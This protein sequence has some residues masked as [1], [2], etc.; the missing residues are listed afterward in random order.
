MKMRPARERGSSISKEAG[1]GAVEGEEA[2]KEQERRAN[3]EGDRQRATKARRGS[4]NSSQLSSSS[5]SGENSSSRMALK[6]AHPQKMLLA[7]SRQTYTLSMTPWEWLAWTSMWANATLKL[8]GMLTLLQ[9]EEEAIRASNYGPRGQRSGAGDQPG[10]SDGTS[11]TNNAAANRPKG[12]IRPRLILDE[13]AIK[14]AVLKIAAAYQLRNL[15]SDSLPLIGLAVQMRIRSLLERML[16]AQ[17]HRVSGH[18]MRPPPMYPARFEG[19]LPAPM[20]DTVMYDDVD[21]IVSTFDRLE[22]EEERQARKDRLA[23]DQ[24]EHEER[25]RIERMRRE[26]EENGEEF[27]MPP[28][29]SAAAAQ[30]FQGD[31]SMADISVGTPGAGAEGSSIPGTPLSAST[32]PSGDSKGKSRELG[33]GSGSAFKEK[34]RKRETPAQ[35]AR[36]MSDDVRKR[37]SD[38]TAQR[39]LGGKK[40]SWLSG[41]SGGTG[42]DSPLG[43]AGKKARSKFPP[44]PPSNLSISTSFPASPGLMLGMGTDGL[45]DT[46]T[47]GTGLPRLNS[48]GGIIPNISEASRSTEDPA[49][50]VITIRDALFVMENEK[51]KG[52]G[53]GSGTRSLARAY[54][55]RT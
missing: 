35:Q 28:T 30:A 8:H 20:W 7:D 31:V 26:A 5:S 3:A 43:G 38:Q 27:V 25:E 41:G 55:G 12:K 4:V 9:A 53:I 52:A 34:K 17:Q 46:G 49:N 11:T 33:S 23:R 37:L 44:L 29:P 51:G 24:A 19:D 18:H 10:G 40:F 22:R 13:Q 45:P 48:T 15:E 1:E 21:K 2:A 36:N 16:E 32:G 39:K 6:G 47:L 50:R 54:M 14:D 42:V